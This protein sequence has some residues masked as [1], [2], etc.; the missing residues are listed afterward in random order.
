MPSR[1]SFLATSGAAALTAKSYAAVRGANGQMNVAF[2]GVGGR[3]QMH[4]DVIL[5]MQK[6]NKGVVPFAVCDVWDGAM[7][8]GK[9][10]VGD[11]GSE[12]SDWYSMVKGPY[13]KAR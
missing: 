2:V 12:N 8:K 9:A 11:P 6:E 13:K 5:A 1:R 3:C 7:V 4:V 10:K